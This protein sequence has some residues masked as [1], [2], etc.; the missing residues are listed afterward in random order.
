MRELRRLQLSPQPEQHLHPS[1]RPAQLATGL[2]QLKGPTLL[3]KGPE[4]TACCQ[5]SPSPLNL[6]LS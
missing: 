6:I 4:R 1:P 2:S 5:C 3:S